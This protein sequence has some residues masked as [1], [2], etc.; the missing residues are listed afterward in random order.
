MEIYKNIKTTS[1]EDYK[2]LK[3]KKQI[4]ENLRKS[5]E[6]IDNKEGI[7]SDIVFKELRQKYKYG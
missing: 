6:E 1:M 4:I 7:E 2:N 5:E 3:I